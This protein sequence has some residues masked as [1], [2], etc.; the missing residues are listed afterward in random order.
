MADPEEIVAVTLSCDLCEDTVTGPERGTGSAAWKLGT[1]KY[2]AHGIRNP[3]AKKP[4]KGDKPARPADQPVGV[5][6]IREIGSGIRDGSRAGTPSSSDLAR[7]F[8]RGVYILSVVAASYA[9]ETDETLITETSRDQLVRELSL[10][11]A[12]SE[13]IMEPIAHAF[14]PTSINKKYGRTI[15]DNVDALASLGEL[16][17]MAFRWR[18]YFRMRE[19]RRPHTLADGTMVYPPGSPPP[20]TQPAA[21]QPAA[22]PQQQQQQQPAPQYIPP[23]GAQPVPQPFAGEVAEQV[24]QAAY[25]APRPGEPIPAF[26]VFGNPAQPSTGTLVT[27]DIVAA[28]RAGR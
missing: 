17:K 1:H 18:R 26:D 12:A 9:A 5:S 23:Q 15:V 21:A 8:G 27:P 4:K 22:P 7:G 11:V 14:A 25:V 24:P 20:G 16:G 3:N 19:E 13:D 6:V 10:S 28:M 2:Q